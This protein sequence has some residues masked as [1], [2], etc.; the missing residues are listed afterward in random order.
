[1]STNN[2]SKYAN[3]NLNASLSNTKGGPSGSSLVTQGSAALTRGGVLL[4][5][6]K[7]SRKPAMHG[8]VEDL[9]VRRLIETFSRAQRVKSGVKLAAPRP[10]NLPSIKKVSELAACMA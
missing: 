7:A 2:Q 5:S 6:S 3:L 9:V 8:P 4:L 10:V 1:M